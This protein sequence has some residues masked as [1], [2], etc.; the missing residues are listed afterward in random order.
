MAGGQGNRKF[1]SSP[2]RDRE[3]RREK[4]SRRYRKKMMRTVVVIGIAVILLGGA[5]LGLTAYNR[6]QE[7]LYDLSVVG[8]GVP[9]VVQVHDPTCPFCVELRGNVESIMDEYEDTEL[10]IRFAEL[11]SDEGALFA[12][13]YGAGRVTLL[14]FNDQGELRAQQAGVQSVNQLRRTFD[15]HLAGDI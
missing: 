5:T 8:A 9:V 11:Q 6:S 12:R 3:R 15:R 13:R 10:R 2:Q 4:E 14:F 1:H 7:D